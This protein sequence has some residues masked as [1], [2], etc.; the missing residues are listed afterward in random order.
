[1]S[2]VGPVHPVLTAARLVK[3]D[4]MFN[5]TELRAFDVDRVVVKPQDGADL[6]Q[7]FWRLL[8]AFHIKLLICRR[9]SDRDIGPGPFDLEAR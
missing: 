6:A 2:V 9:E 8:L 7:L 1:V 3:M 5:P 4:V